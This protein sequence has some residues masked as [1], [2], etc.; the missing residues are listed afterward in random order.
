MKLYKLYYEFRHEVSSK[1]FGDEDDVFVC[2]CR[3]D[4]IEKIEKHYANLFGEIW[5]SNARINDD[6]FALDQM[7]NCPIL[8]GWESFEVPILEDIETG[9]QF[10]YYAVDDGYELEPIK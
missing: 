10:Y 3:A 4:Q 9:E 2:I 1:G 6:R 8:Q 5:E 7:T